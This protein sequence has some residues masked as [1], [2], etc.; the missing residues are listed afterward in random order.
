VARITALQQAEL[1]L[2]VDPKPHVQKRRYS[3]PH[4]SP[5]LP[6]NQAFPKHRLCVHRYHRQC[7]SARSPTTRLV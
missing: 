6:R 4:Q 1:K 7:S 2:S 3:M 5:R